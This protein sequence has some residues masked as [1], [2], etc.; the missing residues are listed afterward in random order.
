MSDE[1]DWP[2]FRPMM[3]DPDAESA[4]DD[5]PAFLA[6]PPGAPVYH[7]F[8]LIE[9]AEVDGWQLGMITGFAAGPNA[10][11]DGYVVAPDGRRAGLVWES[12][13][14]E[15]YIEEVLAPEEG[16]WGVWAIGLPVPLCSEAD[17]GAYLAAAIPFLRPKWEATRLGRPSVD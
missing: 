7:G 6:R 17:A 2:V 10:T 11:G 5:E 3:L 16:R 13:T 14:S 9:G 15:A 1:P 8:P 12:E 4:N